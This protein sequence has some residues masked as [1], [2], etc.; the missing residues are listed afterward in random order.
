MQVILQTYDVGRTKIY[1]R[2]FLD[3]KKEKMFP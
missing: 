3:I 2:A 1:V